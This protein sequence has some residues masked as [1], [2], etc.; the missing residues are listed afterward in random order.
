[1]AFSDHLL[2]IGEDIWDA[3]KDHP[4]VRELADGT[5]DEAAFKHWVTQDYR[6]LQDYARLFALAGATAREESTMTHLLGVGH[7]VLDT[8]MDLHREFAADYGISER[9]LESTEKAPTCL[10]Y[11]NFL[12]RTA[13]EGHEA[14]IVAALYPCMQGYLDVAEH[15]ADLADGEHRYTPFIEMYTGEDFREATGWC[16]AYVD[17]CGERYPGQHD[18][19]EDAFLTS[20]KL[21]HRFWEM[22]YT[23]E[24]WEL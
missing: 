4:F 11:T 15:M 16:R 20:A 14:E 19:M 1:M 12:V 3:Q 13:Y 2:D 9:E 22:A 18:V 6:Y 5:L 24:G 21:E 23:R 10:A 7:Q 8:E 17:R